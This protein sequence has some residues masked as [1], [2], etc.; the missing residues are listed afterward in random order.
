MARLN[1]MLI[2]PNT[3][4]SPQRYLR[5]TGSERDHVCHADH[6]SGAKQRPLAVT[7]NAIVRSAVVASYA[8]D[9]QRSVA[10]VGRG[11]ENA[12]LSPAVNR[13]RAAVG[14]AEKNLIQ[15]YG[16]GVQ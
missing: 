11:K 16:R 6:G 8:G 14:R 7:G 15:A 1:V 9:L 10:R 3:R 5:S 4:I 13:G 12:V 2:I